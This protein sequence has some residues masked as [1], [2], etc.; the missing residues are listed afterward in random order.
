[1]E[2]SLTGPGPIAGGVVSLVSAPLGGRLWRAV[3]NDLFADLFP[4]E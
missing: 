4:P 3:H 2:L 1:L